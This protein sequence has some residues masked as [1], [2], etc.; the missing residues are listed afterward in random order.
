MPL[1]P[2]KI[3][4]EALVVDKYFSEKGTCPYC[5]IIKAESGSARVIWEDEHLFVLAP[6]ASES[7]FGAWFI[8]KRHFNSLTQLQENEKNSLA[9]ALRIVLGKLT[10][11][12]IAYNF[13]FQNSL[14]NE[15]HHM[16]LKLV[17]RPNVWAGLELGTGVI[18]NPMPPES[19]ARFYQGKQP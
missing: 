13:Y 14:D 9:K 15:N 1:V 2:P 12:D 17:P 7:P 3:A 6:F 11:A 18:I 19:A 16:L 4:E 5:D 10:E 8:P